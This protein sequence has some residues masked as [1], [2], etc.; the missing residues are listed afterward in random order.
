MMTTLAEAKRWL[1]DHIREALG[2]RFNYD[3]LM[4]GR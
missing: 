1:V 3:D 4:S 2:T